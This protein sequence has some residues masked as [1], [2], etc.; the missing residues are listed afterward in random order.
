[1]QTLERFRLGTSSPED[2]VRVQ[3][4]LT[5]ACGGYSANDPDTAVQQLWDYDYFSG[6][7]FGR[8]H[9]VRTDSAN[10]PILGMAHSAWFSDGMRLNSI[11]VDPGE[12]GHGIGKRMI[13]TLASVAMRRGLEQI[14][15]Y[16]KPDEQMLSFYQRLGF[17]ALPPSDGRVD[18]E[19][20]S[21]HVPM[22]AP[23]NQILRQ[24]IEPLPVD[25]A[26]I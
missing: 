18:P 20:E 15:L 1:M 11:S 4:L 2:I 12:R 9:V 10:H 17:A 21:R 13:G 14:W 19:T 7:S 16:A 25:P 5:L 23:V 24:P 22:A 26:V 6:G 8:F 3:Q